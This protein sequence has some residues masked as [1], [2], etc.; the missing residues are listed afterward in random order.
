MVWNTYGDVDRTLA[1]MD[2]FRRQMDR[3][4]EDAITGPASSFG[5]YPRATLVESDGA[6]VLSCDVP[7]LGN[8]DIK[9]NL[10]GDQLTVSGERKAEPPE[11]Y[12]VHL[13]ERAGLMFERTFLLPDKVDPDHVTAAVS[14]GVLTVTLP[15]SPE[16]R[17]RAITVAHH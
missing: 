9:L 1:T 16:T 17:P 4:F 15:R 14:D 2:A 12:S 8:S 11:G 6:Y 7:G 5:P 13:D 3:W 10:E